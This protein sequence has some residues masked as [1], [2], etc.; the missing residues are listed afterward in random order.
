[1]AQAH[2][3]APDQCIEN[4][5][6]VECEDRRASEGRMETLTEGP[7]NGP[8][9]QGSSLEDIPEDGREA[10]QTPGEH[11]R[12]ATHRTHP[13]ATILAPNHEGGLTNMRTM[14]HRPGNSLPPPTRMPGLQRPEETTRRRCGG[15]SDPTANPPR[16]ATNDATS[17]PIHPRHR[18]A[19]QHVRG[20]HFQPQGSRP[21]ELT[22][23]RTRHQRSRRSRRDENETTHTPTHY[24]TPPATILHHTE[25]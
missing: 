11:T 13:A 12:T 16:H 14:R 6:N 9:R 17:I 5:P 18:K 2:R 10:T 4:P 20:P 21:D 15:S 1:M 22:T 23:G 8:H 3:Q 7:E 25:A 24:C 19:T